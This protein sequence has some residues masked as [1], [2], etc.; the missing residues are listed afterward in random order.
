MNITLQER[1]LF[2]SIYDK[3]KQQQ[4]RVQ[5]PCAWFH[6]EGMSWLDCIT[7]WLYDATIYYGFDHIYWKIPCTAAVQAGTENTYPE[8]R[9]PRSVSECLYRTCLNVPPAG[10]N[11]KVACVCVCVFVWLC[12]SCSYFKVRETEK[13]FAAQGAT[14]YLVS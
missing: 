3:K 14:T 5:W 13:R 4:N 6:T 1:R 7:N 9:M 10:L 12:P 2:L 8:V 11:W